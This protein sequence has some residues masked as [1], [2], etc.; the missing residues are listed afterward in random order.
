MFDLIVKNGLYFDGCGSPPAIR[1]LGIADGRVV[2][3]SETEF[4]TPPHCRVVDATGM[5][6]MP[7]FVDMHTHYD[8]ELLVAPALRESLRHGVTTVTT[9]SCSISMILSEPEDCSDMFT[10]V[11]SV[12][13]ELVLPLLKEKKTW[14]SPEEYVAFLEDHPVGPNIAG[15]LGHSDLRARVLGLGRSVDPNVKPDERELRAMSSWLE[16][17][18]DAGLLGMS[19]MTNPWDKLDGDRFRSETMPSTRARSKE[20]RQL[21]RVLREKHAILQAV[22]NIVTKYNALT[23]AF[24]SASYFVRKK[25]KTTLLTLADTKATPGLHRVVA[26]L[27]NVFNRLAGAD[28]RLQTLPAPFELY[29]DGIDLVVFEE[30]GAGEAALHLCHEIERNALLKDE[31]YRRKFRKQY[32]DRHSPRVWHRDFD[33]ATIVGCPE[34]SLVGR[35]VGDVAR[36]RGLH[37]VDLFL[38][39]VVVHGKQLR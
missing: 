8:A 30:F 22:P 1:H 28:L 23:F 37:P 27:A 9:G 10:R 19:V 7:G 4:D 12:P 6:V 38:D 3:V 25:L 16:R 11:E 18:I 24:A 35:T 32:E 39:L 36:E 34:A 17:G 13:R 21:Y 29:A 2:C 14:S 5:W 31:T 15:F 26:W 20:L 33:D